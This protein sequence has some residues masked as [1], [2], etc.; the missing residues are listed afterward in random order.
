MPPVWEKCECCGFWFNDRR[1]DPDDEYRTSL[2]FCNSCDE[3]LN[4]AWGFYPY[5][6]DP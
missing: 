2:L 5:G 6:S 3:R 1:E 4:F